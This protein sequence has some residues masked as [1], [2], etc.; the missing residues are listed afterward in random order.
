MNK[1]SIFW[2]LFLSYGALLSLFLLLIIGFSSLELS[3]YLRQN[4]TDEINLSAELKRASLETELRLAVTN[5]KSWTN[6]VI[7]NDL[8]TNDADLRITQTLESFV[9]QYQLPGHLYALTPE[10]SIIAADQQITP[11]LTARLFSK[12]HPLMD[13][14]YP[15]PVTGEIVLAIHQPI[16]ASFNRSLLLGHLLMTY[17]YSA[18]RT[19]L[20]MS[21]QHMQFIIFDSNNHLLMG[22]QTTGILPNR[23][24]NNQ[25]N[26]LL[27]FEPGILSNQQAF[28]IQLPASNKTP[29]TNLWQWWIIADKDRFFQPMYRMLMMLSVA[30]VMI[31][32]LALVIVFLISRR[33]SQPVQVLT[34]MAV[35][36]AKTLDL[37]KRVPIQGNNELS[38]LANA[39]NNMCIKLE[40]MWQAKKQVNQQLNEINQ[41]LE[42][43]VAE[44]TEHLA[45]QATHDPLTSLSNRALLTE[46]LEQA[47]LETQR[48]ANTLAIIFIDLDG[49]KAVNDTFGHD[50]GD[51]LLIEISQR[52][53]SVVREPDT[54]V[55]LGGDEFVILMRLSH[56]D[57][58]NP[59]LER[60]IE[61]VNLPIETETGILKVSP[62]IGIT[63][64][65]DDPSD[66]D[67]LVRHADQAMYEAK[68][69]GRNQ[70]RFF[71]VSMNTLIHSELAQRKEI[72]TALK[73]HQLELFYQPQIELNTGLVVGA[74][75]LIRWQHPDKGLIFPDQF[76][77]VIENTQLMVDLGR[78]VIEN[79]CQQL[80]D[81]NQQGLKLKLSVN[82][83]CC[84]LQHANFYGE[85]I[86]I[87]ANW[88]TVSPEQLVLEIT[89][90]AAIEDMEQTRQILQQ[91]HDAKIR[92]ALDDFGTGF[93]SLTYLRELPVSY[94]K[95][96]KSFVMDMLSDNNDRVIVK[97]IIVL[98][99]N[100]NQLII[101][102]GVETTEH[103]E[104]LKQMNCTFAQGY[105]IAKPMPQVNFIHWFKTRTTDLNG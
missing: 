63:F 104:A 75:A 82:I 18:L 48:Q 40:D 91:C 26:S 44:R 60:I 74:E 46:R 97:S 64:Y 83:S 73:D 89:E 47:L 51:L 84:H 86:E 77:P 99:E 41:S 7:M 87:L 25:L 14:R 17:P 72:R 66:S 4:A 33:I 32:S 45:W 101:A 36:I 65:P 69:Q 70:V 78:W 21:D 94:L 11:L 100:F 71:N 20:D 49:F 2:Q 68:Q 1:R 35:D 81:W 85:L 29:L 28:I 16:Y 22:Q 80:S 3:Q 105:G 31:I 24:L 6:L 9:Q 61:L 54:V 50:M 95:I 93:S 52:F 96:D 5:L 42:K 19:R 38:Q 43:K 23:L 76:L 62:S 55:R 98:A 90:S 79:A 10:G 88:P 37:S 30:G 15:D 59:P 56:P 103:C 39:F 58:I 13:D 53:L 92:T 27:P 67:T 102:E 34:K 8:L 12:Q 57:M